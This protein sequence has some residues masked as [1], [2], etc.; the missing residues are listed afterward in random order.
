MTKKA[1]LYTTSAVIGSNGVT[2]MIPDAADIEALWLDPGMGDGITDLHY[3]SVPIGKPL[4]YFRTHPDALYR[5]R[6]E[7]LTIKHEGVIGE[8]FF[9]VAPAMRGQI[10][11]ARPVTLVT[12]V[13][14]NGSPRLWP[15]NF[16]KEGGH[17]NEALMTARAAAKAAT[18]GWVSLCGRGVAMRLVPLKRVTHRILTSASSRR[19]TSL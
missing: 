6:T 4:D 7:S 17:D 19:L 3:H 9:I 8:Q 1:K 16:P 5:R 13:S 14:R 11:E 15:I 2:S 10:E 18:S 12:V